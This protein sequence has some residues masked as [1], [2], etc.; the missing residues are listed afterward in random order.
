MPEG[1]SLPGLELL[2][3]VIPFQFL[4]EARRRELARRLDWREFEPGEAILRRGERSRDL[5]L[6]A[7]GRVEA[8]TPRGMVSLIEPGHYF[9]ERSAL[10]SQPRLVDVVAVER[11]GAWSLPGQD[12]L[13]LVDEEPAF[14]MALAGVLK[15][16]Q[17]IFHA[18][19]RLY[20][21]ILGLVDRREFLLSELV[22]AYLELEPALHGGIAAERIDVPALSYAVARLPATVTRTFS[23]YLAGDLPPL[24]RDAEAQFVPVP[25][26]ARR[27]AAWQPLPGKLLLLLRDGISDVTDLL[28]CLCLYAVEA[29][30]IRRRA[31]SQELLRELARIPAALDPAWE[32]RVVPMLR[33]EPDEYEGLRR[34]W[35]REFWERL[36]ELLLHH[37]D[38]AIE[39]DLMVDHYNSRASEVWAGQIRALA[40]RL[41]D[42][43]D[44][45]L[46]VHVVSSNT[47][48]VSN[49]LSTWVHRRRD[50]LLAWGRAERADLCGP[51]GPGRPWGERWAN[52]EDLVYVLARAWE[53]A[54]PGAAAEREEEEAAHGHLRLRE[55]AFTGI[56]VGLFDLRRVDPALCDPGL[57]VRAAARPTLLVNVDFAFGQQAEEILATLLFQFG[58]RVRSVNVLGKAGG[59]TG[60][61]GDLLLPTAFLLQTN[62]EVYALP[63]HD[64]PAAA[65]RAVAPQIP[66]H[67]G[68]VLTVAG[69]LL[70][71]R[72]LLHYYQRF[73]RCVGLEMEGSFFARQLAAAIATG[74]VGPAVRSRFAYYVSDLPLHAGATLSEPLAPEVGVPPLYAI[75]RAIL[76]RVLTG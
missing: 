14:A 60:Q 18:Y 49:C 61:R 17:G 25:S 54:H 38:V 30:K 75:T 74:V 31:R 26:R 10:F 13:A 33:L 15:V 57:A 70:Q 6:L 48:S 51:P 37:E 63:N 55:T 29:K 3:R 52:R 36:R 22:P 12:L 45:E 34:V 71:D 32:A 28:T 39:C 69:T 76:A 66:V 47:H 27:R 9:G 58:R 67:E 1:P 62:D 35:P 8:R 41:V 68:A 65:L 44:P 11:V 19:R 40:A 72:V 16:K 56:E 50:E 5:F 23:W 73:W 42:L 46:E 53:A 64:L 21:R 43:E 24:Y 20:A 7:E 4:S 2:G 59:V